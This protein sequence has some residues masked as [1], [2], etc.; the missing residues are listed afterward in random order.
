MITENEL[1]SMTLNLGYERLM[2]PVL[3]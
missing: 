1:K 2:T 3:C